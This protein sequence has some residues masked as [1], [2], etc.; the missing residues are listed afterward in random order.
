MRL[1]IYRFPKSAAIQTMSLIDYSINLEYSTSP[2]SSF[3]SSKFD[4]LI[5]A[6]QPAL[7]AEELIKLD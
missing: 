4:N 3:T 5:S 6:I 7:R 2:K 1:S